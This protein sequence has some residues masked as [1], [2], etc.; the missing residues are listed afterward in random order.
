MTEGVGKTV[1]CFFFLISGVSF[2]DNS[3]FKKE[4]VNLVLLYKIVGAEKSHQIMYAFLS[5]LL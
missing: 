4:E 1:S 2:Y 5:F 3:F